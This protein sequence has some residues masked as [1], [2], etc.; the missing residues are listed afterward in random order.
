HLW[1]GYSLEAQRRFPEAIA[2]RSRARELDPLAAT[3]TGGV[4]SAILAAHGDYGRA[5]RLYR[6]A[7]ELDPNFWQAYDSFGTLLEVTGDLDEARRMF[8]RAVELAGRTQR[9][10]AG[11]ARVLARANSMPEAR[12]LL[13]ELRADAVATGIR[14]PTVAPALYVAGDS[15]GA[16][17]WLEAAYRQRHPELMRINADRAY[18]SMRG[19]PRFQEILRRVGLRG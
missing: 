14:H 1:Y 10:K 17:E 12:K 9:A 4:G 7:I 6:D 11:L 13:N 16:I 19:D 5:K 8:E 3:A 15:A 2:E 18:D